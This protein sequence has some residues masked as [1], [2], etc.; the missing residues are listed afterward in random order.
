L[1][2]AAAFLML[3]LAWS[4]RGTPGQW[5]LVPAVLFAAALLY[6]QRVQKAAGASPARRAV[7]RNASNDCRT[8]TGLRPAGDRFN[9]EHHVYGADLDLFGRQGLFARLSTARTPMGEST[10]AGWLLAPRTSR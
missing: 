3:A 6:H 8:A 2:L 4:T 10:L 1:T 5:L 9:D 7:Y